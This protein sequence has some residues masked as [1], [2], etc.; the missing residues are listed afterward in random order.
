MKLHC[1][2]VPFK[3][4]KIIFVKSKSIDPEA[5]DHRPLRSP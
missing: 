5:Y 4:P 2:N 1:V 3:S